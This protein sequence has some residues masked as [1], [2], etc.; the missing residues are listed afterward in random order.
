MAP[1]QSITVGFRLTPEE[2]E[3]LE[4]VARHL[5]A[6]GRPVSVGDAARA[7]VLRDLMKKAPKDIA[8]RLAR[9]R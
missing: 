5:P 7:L 3:Q 4:K 6:L 2:Y 1:K 9:G 8:A